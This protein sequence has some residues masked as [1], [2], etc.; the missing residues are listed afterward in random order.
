MASNA[1]PS[2]PLAR[3]ATLQLSGRRSSRDRIEA[4]LEVSSA[5]S[6]PVQ[7]VFPLGRA[8]VVNT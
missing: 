4:I 7:L 3:S 6:N 8:R 1:A 5:K 2:P